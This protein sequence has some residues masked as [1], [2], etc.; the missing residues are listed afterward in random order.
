[1]LE[2]FEKETFNYCPNCGAKMNKENTLHIL[3]LL[4]R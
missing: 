3:M 4:K 1:M 2:Y